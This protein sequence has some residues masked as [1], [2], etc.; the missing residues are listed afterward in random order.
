VAAGTACGA[1]ARNGT[2]DGGGDA[3]WFILYNQIKALPGFLL[4]PYYVLYM[5]DLPA[6]VNAGNGIG[7]PKHAAQ[8]RHM[9]GNRTEMRK[10]NWDFIN[11]TAWQTGRMASGIG[12]SNDRNLT[13]NA[14]ATRNWLGYTWYELKWKPRVAVGFDYASGDG[15]ANCANGTTASTGYRCKTANTFENFFP[16]NYIHAGYMLNHAWRN[17]I[18][19]QVN[20][21]ARPSERDHIEFWGQAHFLA[22]ARDNWYRGAQGPLVYSRSDNTTSHVGNETDFAWTR[23]FADGKVSFTVTYGHFFAGQ[24]V[25]NNLGTYADQDWGIMQLWMNF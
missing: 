6:S 10:G 22:N 11:E 5:N 8:T 19:P 15:N 7:T 1:A 17:S 2:P 24:Y 18:Q 20:I 13:I 21:Q 23:M 3:N 9:F 14:W 4:E 25:K 12:G 16:T